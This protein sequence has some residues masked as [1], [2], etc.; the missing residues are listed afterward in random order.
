MPT[1][2]THAAI[3]LAA[4][5]GLGRRAVPKPLLLAGVI[6]SML[7]DADVVGFALGVPW[8]SAYAHRGFTH[9]IAF[10]AA[11]ALA[12]A[13][14]FRTRMPLRRAI[15][16]LFVAMASHGILDAF[17]NGGS[18]IALLWPWTDER[19]AAPVRVIE[20]S[21]IGIAPFF[22]ARGLSVLASEL[23]WVW[24]P[25]VVIATLLALIRSRYTRT[26]AV[27]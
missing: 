7:P 17:T 13:C 21:P 24:L 9:S 23:W 27:R 26:F 22:S 5:I 1:I 3:P 4:G 8:G 14:F 11:V 25:C 2:L 19:F 18:G 15:A 12:V 16:F 6:V 10:A 20:V